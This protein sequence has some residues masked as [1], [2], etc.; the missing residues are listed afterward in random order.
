MTVE[1]D[2]AAPRPAGDEQAGGAAAGPVSRYDEVAGRAAG[3]REAPAPDDGPETAGHD[4]PH[5][6]RNGLATAIP[7]AHPSA[8][9]PDALFPDPQ[10][11]DRWRRRFTAVRL[12][13]PDPARDDPDRAVYL[14]NESGRF[15]LTCWDATTGASV[16]ATDR[17]DGTVHGTLSADGRSL[18]WFDDHDGDEFGVWRC[19]PFGAA[20]GTAEEALPAVPPGYPAG[21]AVGNTLAIAGFSDDDGTRIHLARD[22]R[23]DQVYRHEAD[24]GVGALATDESIWVL[25]HSE[26]GDSR[27][28]ALRAFAVADGAVLAELDDSPGKG[29]TAIA[30][31][32]VP[33]DQ[34]LLV[35]H[36]RR[37]RDELGIWDLGTG[38]FT[39]LDIDLPGDLDAE[40][41]P[42]GSALIVLHTHQG[43]SEL[44]R[45]QLGTGS[46]TRLP[47]A[48][49][50][51]SGAIARRDGSV[52]YRHSSAA[53]GWQLRVL[54][55]DG[56]DRPLIA[57][58]D[59]GPPPSQPVT[60]IWVDGPGGRIHALLARPDH[61]APV[62]DADH[63]NQAL[64]TVF[65][66][67]GG[68]ASADE[69]SFDALRATYLD[70]GLAV[71]QVN[72]RGSTGYGSAWRDA[73]TAR[74][75]H[76]ELADIA[77]VH[78]HLITRGL[79]D[80]ERSA[81][82]GH[83]WGGFL[84][85][86]AL[87]TQ[88]TRWAVGVA[89]VPVADYLAA[90]ADEM[91]PMRAYDRAL[92][93]GSPQEK[94]DAYADSSPLSWIDQVAAPVLV[95]AGEND[96]RCPIRQIDNYLDALAA[97]GAEYAVYRYHAGHG[98]MVIAERLRQVA[99]EVAFV[100][101]RLLP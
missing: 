2:D 90:Y 57:P 101:D 81:I 83:S 14:S 38:R 54:G 93:G 36:E 49:G 37:G 16:Q 25:S 77:C 94:P 35:G 27:Y 1:A 6:P 68:P 24:G 76:T 4:D 63:S 74:I 99:C 10:A 82:A 60:D 48:T 45:Y 33:G 21:V 40:F 69:D 44:Y 98:S 70:A 7:A 26:H 12:S 30:F 8:N 51:I 11:E 100:R 13:L 18:W 20:P 15:E 5:R 50:V 56:A 87:G 89:G 73:L 91:E 80:P 19:Q 9:V 71:C 39:E 67:H 42:D 79:V 66:V 92:F 46:L 34:R 55:P 72:Y 85:L 86:L 53:D 3:H 52:W 78:D 96:P 62:A 75:G 29:L 17:P 58:P 47:A 31:S 61:A 84:A 88:P 32:P 97:R 23:I 64:P 41:Y 59:G 22:G 43:R 65:L 95:F 28:P